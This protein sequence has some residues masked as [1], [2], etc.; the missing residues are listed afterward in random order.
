MMTKN[1]YFILLLLIITSCTVNDL[2]LEDKTFTFKL[3]NYTDTTWNHATLY[4]G[5]NNSNGDFIAIDSVKYT[6]VPSNIS[7]INDYDTGDFYGSNGYHDGYYY[8]KIG[9]EQYVEIPYPILEYGSLMVNKDKIAEISNTFG[10]MVKLSD[11]QKKYIEAYNI[12]EGIDD[13]SGKNRVFVTLKIKATGI[14]GSV[15]T[16]KIYN[17]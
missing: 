16:S 5:A 17:N 1:Y 11:G 7:P 15:K 2:V 14:T 13:P 9:N 6:P 8:Y 4:V 12:Y 3:Q 10:F